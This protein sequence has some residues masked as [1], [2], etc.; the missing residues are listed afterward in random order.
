EVE[1]ANEAYKPNSPPNASAI[2]SEMTSE[3]SGTAG[4]QPAG[5]PGALSN[6]PPGA[7]TAPVTLTNP[8]GATTAGSAPASS[9]KELTRNYEV[10]KSVQ[11]VKQQVGQL[12]RVNAAVVVN[13]KPVLQKDGGVKSVPLTQAEIN[14]IT[15]LVQ[16]AVGYNKE[17]GDSVKVVNAAFADRALEVE[18]KSFLEKLTDY[19]VSHTTDIIKILLIALVLAY[20]LFG[21][22]RP[23][24]RDVIRPKQD[25][26]AMGGEEGGVALTAEELA[27]SEVEAEV[28][29]EAEA[30]AQMAAFS[31][32]LLR[33]KDMAREDPRMVATII[34][35]W[36]NADPGDQKTS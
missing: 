22:V 24:L 4:T 6:Q 33:A 27:Q 32:L 34:R 1:Q 25:R 36:L 14:Q 3:G 8:P 9:H 23:I 7:A 10:D 28:V 21:V 19:I 17:R 16:E 29:A 26:G 2:R 31:E 12:K 20:L 18:G 15:N 35:E 13:F 5:V 11:H 30:N